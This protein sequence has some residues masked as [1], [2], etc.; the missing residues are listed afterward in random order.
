M[1]FRDSQKKILIYIIAL[2][3]IF[4]FLYNNS[5]LGPVKKFSYVF[6]KS[7]QSYASKAAFFLNNIA[8]YIFEAKNLSGKNSRLLAENNNLTA[9]I[10]ELKEIKRENDL[11]RSVLN[12]PIARERVLIDAAIIGKDPY[13]FSNV[14]IIDRGSDAR[15]GLGMDAVDSNG[16]FVGKIIEAASSVSQIRT[17]LDSSSAIS[18]VDQETRV[19]GI[20]KND[21]S[22]GL[23]FDMV[24][25]NEKI[26]ADDTII[27]FW[28]GNESV[29]PIAKVV[30][31][32]KSP[33]KLFQK[34][35]LSP[36]ADFKNMEKIFIIIK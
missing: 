14:I 28:S 36:L 21:L 26:E 16:F 17:M 34:I 9:E 1:I 25:Q 15:I 24:S 8:S 13:S 32:E 11:L 10:S 2:L 23:V 29:L 18:A 27:A 4:V 22:D 5:G 35:K 19:Q 3:A 30:S 12:L 33:N 20:V 31:V 7:P 6:F